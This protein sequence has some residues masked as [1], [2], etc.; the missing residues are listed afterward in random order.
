M[1]IFITQYPYRTIK[2]VQTY[3]TVKENTLP[4]IVAILKKISESVR[5]LELAEMLA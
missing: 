2:D 5:M 4:K 1:S 3:I